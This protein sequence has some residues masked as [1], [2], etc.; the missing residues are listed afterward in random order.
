L[1]QR[2]NFL[3]QFSDVAVM[4]YDTSACIFNKQKK[5]INSLGSYKGQYLGHD[6]EKIAVKI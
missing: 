3:T 1:S 5:A 6:N 2:F 4:V